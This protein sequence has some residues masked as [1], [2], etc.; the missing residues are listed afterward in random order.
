VDALPALRALLEDGD[1]RGVARVHP[2]VF[3]GRDEPVSRGLTWA[4]RNRAVLDTPVVARLPLLVPRV[5]Q[6]HELAVVVRDVQLDDID[7]GS[8]LVFVEALGV[9]VVDDVDV[10][11]VD[12]GY[13]ERLNE[14][15]T[16]PDVDVV[17]L[18]VANH[19][20][21]F[22]PLFYTW[23]QKRKTRHNWGIEDGPV[24][25]GPGETARYRL[26]APGEDARM[27]A[28]YPT[29]I[30]VFEKGAQRWKSIHF[31]PDREG[32]SL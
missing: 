5:E 1:L 4:E 10:D 7:V 29:Q 15:E 28:G 11:V 6:G 2:G 18:D 16:A 8:G 12:Y 14:D 27:N 20:R 13:A 24:P 23:D 9:A 26:V 25:L 21:E 3:S 31:T 19:D 22:V 32:M 17:E 30:T